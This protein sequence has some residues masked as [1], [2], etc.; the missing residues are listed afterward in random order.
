MKY[1]MGVLDVMCLVLVYIIWRDM[2]SPVPIITAMVGLIATLVL[3]FGFCYIT[4]TIH[5]R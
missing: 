2:T 3:L 4:L 1:F 5:K